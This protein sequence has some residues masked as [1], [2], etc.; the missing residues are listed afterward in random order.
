MLSN[1]QLHV[2][3]YIPVPPSPETGVQGWRLLTDDGPGFKMCEIQILHCV[4]VLMS[5]SRQVKP[6]LIGSGMLVVHVVGFH[7]TRRLQKSWKVLRLCKVCG[8]CFGGGASSGCANLHNSRA[9]I[10]LHEH[11]VTLAQIRAGSNRSMIRKGIAGRSRPSSEYACGNSCEEMAS[12]TQ[13]QTASRTSIL[14]K[15]E[16][17]KKKKCCWTATRL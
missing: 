13:P 6:S 7:V 9:G 12:T 1:G 8:I 15:K 5:P 14:P 10:H 3:P 11:C 4:M 17:R 16:G 2:P